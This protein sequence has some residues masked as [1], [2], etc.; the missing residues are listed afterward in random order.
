MILFLIHFSLFKNSSTCRDIL[1]NISDLLNLPVSISIEFRCLSKG[2]CFRFLSELFLILRAFLTSLNIIFV[3]AFFNSRNLLFAAIF[4]LQIKKN[5]KSEFGRIFVEISL[6][7]IQ[8]FLYFFEKSNWN[9][10]KI[11][12]NMGHFGPSFRK[13]LNW[14][15]V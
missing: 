1:A 7:S 2:E 5:F 14:N 6:P 10:F 8:Q 13:T 12:F 3:S 4:R 11:S 15:Y 9:F